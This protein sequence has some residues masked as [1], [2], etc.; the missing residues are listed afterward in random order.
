MAPAARRGMVAALEA[1]AVAEGYT[2]VDL[3]GALRS[4]AVVRL[5]HE[6]AEVLR[7]R[8]DLSL[9]E[10]GAL[11]GGRA[12]TTVMHG[13]DNMARDP[14]V[15]QSVLTAFAPYFRPVPHCASCTC[16]GEVRISRWEYDELRRKA[17]KR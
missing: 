17:G 7:E 9:T 2:M 4:S 5:R 3:C 16:D 8:T 14:G 10:I 15:R 13:L 12:Y 6:I 11:L 1:V